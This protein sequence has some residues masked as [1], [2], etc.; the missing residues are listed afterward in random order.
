MT[1]PQGGEVTGLWLILKGS[2]HLTQK[3]YASDNVKASKKER[4]EFR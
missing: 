4:D 2:A 1:I 3:I